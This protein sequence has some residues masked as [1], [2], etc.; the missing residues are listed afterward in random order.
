MSDRFDPSERY[1]YY[2]R[3]ADIVWIP[4]GSSDDAVSEET[5]WGLID[6]DASS[7]AVVGIEIWEASKRLPEDLLA[8]LPRPADPKPEGN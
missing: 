1:A 3:E 7:D 4:T 5:S 2:D 8:K 6:H